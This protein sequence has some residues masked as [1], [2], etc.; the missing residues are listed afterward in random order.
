M[1]PVIEQLDIHSNS[2]AFE[3]YI[4]IILQPISTTVNFGYGRSFTYLIE[5]SI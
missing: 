1:T 4:T 5:I 3:D 2:E